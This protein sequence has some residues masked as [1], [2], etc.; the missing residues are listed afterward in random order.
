VTVRS[1][2]VSVLATAFSLAAIGQ[3]KKPLDLTYRAESKGTVVAVRDVYA[4]GKGPTPASAQASSATG[5]SLDTGMPVG[6]VAYWN[7]GPGAGDGM[8][9]GAVG[10]GDMQNWLTDHAKEVVVKMDDGE[11]RTFRP[12][13]PGRFQVNERV[14]VRGGTIEPQGEQAR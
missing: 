9:V 12:P 10:R 4:T 6:A 2:L 13:N 14:A 11:T 3:T 1:F 7:F 5:S 8:K